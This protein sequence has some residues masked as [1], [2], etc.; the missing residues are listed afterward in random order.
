M[1]KRG[2]VIRLTLFLLASLLSLFFISSSC[3]YISI[4]S[5][6]CSAGGISCVAADAN[7]CTSVLS[8]PIYNLFPSGYC[9]I[10]HL[11][12]TK[13]YVYLAG[14]GTCEYVPLTNASLLFQCFSGTPFL[15]ASL[16]S[17]WDCD[18]IRGSNATV[19]VDVIGNRNASV[20]SAVQ[21][22]SGVKDQA[23]GFSGPAYLYVPNLSLSISQ[24]FWAKASNEGFWHFYVNSNG[25]YYKDTVVVSDIPPIFTVSGI[26][27]KIG[28]GYNGQLDEIALYNR[29]FTALEVKNLSDLYGKETEA[30]FSDLAGTKINSAMVNQTIAGTI[31]GEN[32]NVTGYVFYNST[33]I[34]SS[35]SI[36]LNSLVDL[37]F[38]NWTPDHAQSQIYFNVSYIT[39]SGVSNLI[40]S[41]TIDINAQT[42]P[43]VNSPPVA[44]IDKTQSYITSVGA[45]IDFNQSSYDTDDPLNLTW[46]FGDGASTTIPYYSLL[47]KNINPSFGNANHTYTTGGLKTVTLTA[48]EMVRGQSDQDSVLVYVFKEGINVLANITRPLEGQNINEDLVRFNASQSYVANCTPTMSPFNFSAGNLKCRYIHSPGQKDTLTYNLTVIWNFNGQNL[49]GNWSSNYNTTV[50][51]ARLYL[52]AGN[53]NA[54]LNITYQLGNLVEMGSSEVNFFANGGWTCHVSPDNAIWTHYGL[55]D[56]NAVSNCN[57]YSSYTGGQGCCPTNNASCGEN[58]I[59]S[60]GR[61]TLCS[62]FNESQSSCESAGFEIANNTMRYIDPNIQCSVSLFDAHGCQYTDTCSCKWVN[63]NCTAGSIRTNCTGATSGACYFYTIV[64]NKCDKP[65]N[66]LT[67]FFKVNSASTGTNCTESSRVLSCAQAE[68]ELP[69]FGI[70]SFIIVLVSVG[71]VYFI[72]TRKKDL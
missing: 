69:F 62:E 35:R 66:S 20:I 29:T 59:C 15:G 22:P 6:Y 36:Q 70:T 33:G 64:E 52:T 54:K 21:G 51:F 12:F 18:T 60:G 68:G 44:I 7:Y 67:Y 23:Y 14:A 27:L 31:S 39:I 19:A 71:L 41:N 45:R 2:N 46:D 56:V 28:Y 5:S 57:L 49:M 50:D 4:N 13:P 26:D 47:A 24:S 17:Y 38:V 61:K 3:D 72:S 53:Y 40:K 16:I 55:S 63:G 43:Q 32:L 42:S 8:C 58:G 1:V 65:E 30:Y 11:T 48:R 10:S 25:T 9:A 37:F 34:I